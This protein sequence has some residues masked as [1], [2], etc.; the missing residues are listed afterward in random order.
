MFSKGVIEYLLFGYL[1]QYKLLRLSKDVNSV[2]AIP[3]SCLCMI[4]SIRSCKSGILSSRPLINRFAISLKNTP[5]LQQGSKNVV[6]GSS[7]NS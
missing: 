6:F 2:I 1:E 3:Y 4:W 7:N 5:D